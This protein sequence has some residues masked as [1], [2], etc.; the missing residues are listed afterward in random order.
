MGFAGIKPKYVKEMLN[1]ITVL[2]KKNK[3]KELI[4][5]ET[6]GAPYR[7]SHCCVSM[8]AYTA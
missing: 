7:A 3:D 4:V 1:L 2:D 8:L 5:C 6:E